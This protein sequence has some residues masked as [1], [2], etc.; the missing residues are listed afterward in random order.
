M[1][2]S[3]RTT[4]AIHPIDCDCSSC[5]PGGPALSAIEE[6]GNHIVRATVVGFV[7]GWVITFFLDLALDGPGMFVGFGL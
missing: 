1:S 4:P 3:V 6:S 7:L 2:R 5:E